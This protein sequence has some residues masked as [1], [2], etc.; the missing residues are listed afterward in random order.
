VIEDNTL[1]ATLVRLMLERDGC[2]VECAAS[3]ARALELLHARPWD[4][5][6]MDCQMPDMDGYTVTRR[7]RQIEIAEGRSRLPIVALT[8]HA[9]AE[10]RRRCLDAGMDE[11]LSKPLRHEVMRASLARLCAVPG[12]APSPEPSSP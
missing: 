10:D 8:A 1:N 2:T 4:I 12:P 9:L 5:A 3:G 11:Y 7:W 6:L